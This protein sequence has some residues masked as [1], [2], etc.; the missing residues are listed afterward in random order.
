M[1]VSVGSYVSSSDT[2]SG[3][4]VNVEVPVKSGEL[5]V[6]CEMVLGYIKS[7]LD[8]PDN[9][10]TIEELLDEVCNIFPASDKGLVSCLAAQVY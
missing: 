6:V 7:A 1:T 5:C 9:E 3:V 4:A 8:D 2:L 10:K